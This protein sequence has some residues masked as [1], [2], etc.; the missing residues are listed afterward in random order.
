VLVTWS[1]SAPEQAGRELSSIAAEWGVGVTEAVDRL[2]PAGAIYWTMDEAD[3]QRVLRFEHTMIGSDGLPHDTHPHPRLWGTFPRVLGH[4]CRELGLFTLEEAVRRMTL[5][6]ARRFGLAGR[7]AVAAGGYADIT[8]F[9]PATVLDRATFAQ[10]IAPAAGIEHVFV[11]GHPVWSGAGP[12]GER[13]GRALRRQAMQSE[14]RESTA[15]QKA[16]IM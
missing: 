4:Y 8:V 5:L 1:K 11:N 10:P 12:T 6:P 7:G 16:V 15:Q 14:A 3:V 13:P 2:Q 9:D